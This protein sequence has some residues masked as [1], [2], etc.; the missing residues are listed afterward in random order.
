MQVRQAL[1]VKL[2]L[3]FRHQRHGHLDAL[4][5]P[6]PFDDL[7]DGRATQLVKALLRKFA[8][9][10]AKRLAPSKVMQRHGVGDG[11]VTVEQVSLE[12]A[13]RDEKLGSHLTVYPEMCSGNGDKDPPLL[14]KPARNGAPD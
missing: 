11:A 6:Q 14:P 7:D 12:I 10:F 5:A 8:A 3:A 9:P 13:G 2:F 4:L 1:V